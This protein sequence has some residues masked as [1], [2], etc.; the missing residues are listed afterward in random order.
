MSTDI[1]ITSLFRGSQASWTIFTH[2]TISKGINFSP[3]ILK[4]TLLQNDNII[5]VCFTGMFMNTSLSVDISTQ[6]IIP[7]QIFKMHIHYTDC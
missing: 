3:F 4:G 7:L 2:C 5:N 1:E 6:A